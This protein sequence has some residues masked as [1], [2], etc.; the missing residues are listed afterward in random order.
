MNATEIKVCCFLHLPHM[1][2]FVGGSGSVVE[3]NR[4][5][6]VGGEGGVIYVDASGT[7]LV[8]ASFVR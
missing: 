3:A 1:L 5:L 2:S 7:T 8:D 4:A 6:G